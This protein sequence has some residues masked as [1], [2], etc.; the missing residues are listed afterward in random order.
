MKTVN[1]IREIDSMADRI[2]DDVVGTLH[3]TLGKSGE[4]F[5]VVGRLAIDGPM[6]GGEAKGAAVLWTEEKLSERCG[7]IAG[8]KRREGR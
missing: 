3:E 4:V 8:N 7:F 6:E 1:G 2:S 5:G